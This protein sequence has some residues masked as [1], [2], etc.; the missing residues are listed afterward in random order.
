MTKYNFFSI[1]NI[2]GCDEKDD[3][4]IRNSNIPE[5]LKENIN[6]NFMIKTPTEIE[7]AA[8][9]KM[10]LKRYSTEKQKRMKK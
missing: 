3:L 7:K 8:E 2:K 1:I 6:F 5:E 4:S 10:A 9:L